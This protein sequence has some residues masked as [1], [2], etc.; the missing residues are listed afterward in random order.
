MSLENKLPQEVKIRKS[1]FIPG[2]GIYNYHSRVMPFVDVCDEDTQNKIDNREVGLTLYNVGFFVGA[3][4]L[5][6][7][8]F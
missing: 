1:D 4:Y 8:Y 3:L 2:L 6:S 5:Y 7:Q